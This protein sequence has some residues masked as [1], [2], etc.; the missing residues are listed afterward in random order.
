MAAEYQIQ[1]EPRRSSMPSMMTA[2]PSQQKRPRISESSTP[3]HPVSL[4]KARPPRPS[5]SPVS[6]R[7]QSPSHT[8]SSAESS[9]SANGSQIKQ[10]VSE[11]LETQGQESET[12]VT[13][14]DQTKTSEY[15]SEDDQDTNVK[16]EP[17]TES[18]LD[19]EITGVEM[20]DSSLS[21]QM[22]FGHGDWSGEGSQ[23]GAEGYDSGSQSEFGNS[24]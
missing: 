5:Q 4:A 16:L 8:L 2:S 15:K 1:P 24:K 22:G 3:I 13:E 9:Q 11:S 19:L 7:N 23:G 10:E 20:G 21:G 14:T 6:M 18:E 12:P 17:M